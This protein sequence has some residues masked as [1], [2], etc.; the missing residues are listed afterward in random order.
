M[1]IKYHSFRHG[2]LKII[3]FPHI[4]F[5][6]FRFSVFHCYCT[7]IWRHEIMIIDAEWFE[8]SER[9]AGNFD[10]FLLLLFLCSLPH[11]KLDEWTVNL[12]INWNTTIKST[13]YTIKPCWTIFVR[14]IGDDAYKMFF[15]CLNNI[16]WKPM[17]SQ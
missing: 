17:F 6:F 4:F 8:M 12:P 7:L 15:F 2:S 14:V 10:L 11:Q 16:S 5:S 9:I 1:S 3:S 13:I